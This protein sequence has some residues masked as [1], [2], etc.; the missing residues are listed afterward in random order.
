MAYSDEY[1]GN[2][3]ENWIVR[4]YHDAEGT[5]D[6]TGVSTD[7]YSSYHPIITNQP[8]IRRSIDL[9]NSKA[10]TG[11]IS[12]KLINFNYQ[13]SPFSEVL[14]GGSKKYINRK[15]EVYSRLVDSSQIIY[16]GRLIDISHDLESISL[17]ITDK[18]PSD[19]ISIPNQS[20]VT[21]TGIMGVPVAYGD[22]HHQYDGTN[23]YD[24]FP[25]YANN[26][27]LKKDVWRLKPAPFIK[28]AGE[29]H[30]YS[31]GRYANTDMGRLFYFDKSLNAP[32]PL[33]LQTATGVLENGSYYSEAKYDFKRGFRYSPTSTESIDSG[34]NDDGSGF[35]SEDTLIAPDEN[36]ESSGSY[37]SSGSIT[38]S[39]NQVL[40]KTQKY[41]FP[42]PEGTPTGV[43][44]KIVFKWTTNTPAYGSSRFVSIKYSLDGNT[45]TEVNNSSS[46]GGFNQTGIKTINLSS[47]ELAGDIYFKMQFTTSGGSSSL[48][49]GLGMINY[50]YTQNE[51]KW[52]DGDEIPKVLYSWDNGYKRSWDIGNSA[53]KV[54][55]VHRDILQRFTGETGASGYSDL[56]TEKANWRVH[57]SSKLKERELVQPLLDRLQF[58]GGFVYLYGVDGVGRYIFIKSSYSSGDVAETFNLNDISNI[59]I[60]NSSFSSIVTK[61]NI[62][63]RKQ[64]GSGNHILS[65]SFT[66]S[67]ART[68][69]NIPTLENIQDVEMKFIID[70][71]SG[72][73]TCVDFY[74]YYNNI[75]G[76]IKIIVKCNIV[77]P[78]KMDLDVGDIVQF[79]LDTKPFGYSW[80]QYYMIT[81]LTR[82]IGEMNIECREVG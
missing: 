39:S 30:R 9:A 41:S 40:I 75:N 48:G 23:I 2:I 34:A 7:T 74:N 42:R 71:D 32:I 50:A 68:N 10:K 57:W 55:E 3:Y 64:L 14:L 81:S 76:D 38:L 59:S 56:S 21:P 80:S 46:N 4:L 22:F 16:T 17:T 33:A 13:G 8:S 20:L 82:K 69:W 78:A 51:F 18:R 25:T 37:S 49:A 72:N 45:Y 11:N 28:S 73:S 70:T 24:T 44:G 19:F 5:N 58:E 29:N 52:V 66:N 53:T 36:W 77:N 61:V 65:E 1:K 63:A 15:V 27:F 47:G 79:D 35:S 26:E 60:A 54:H 12:L 31:L 67:T 62:K 43:Q 6:W